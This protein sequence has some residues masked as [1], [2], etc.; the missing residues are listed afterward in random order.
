MNRKYILIAASL[1]AIAGC[2]KEP[3]VVDNGN[4]DLNNSS[5]KI[6]TTKTAL[7]PEDLDYVNSQIKL[8][9]VIKNGDSYS[10]LINGDI[11]SYA[12][13]VWTYANEPTSKYQWLVDNGGSKTKVDHFFFG[14][15]NQDKDNNKA[16]DLFGSGL[17][18]NGSGSSYSVAIPSTTMTLTSAQFD[19]S[20]IDMVQRSR[21]ESNYSPVELTL[22]HYFT[23]FAIK[24]HNYT[25]DQITITGIKLYGI[26]NVNSGSIAFDTEECTSTPSYGTGS[27]TWATAAAGLQLVGSSNIAIS[28]DSEVSN[29]IT[30]TGKLTTATDAYY[31]MWPQSASDLGSNAKLDITYQVNGGAAVTATVG[32][33]PTD[34]TYGWAAG[35]K[36]NV[37]IAFRDKAV[38]LTATVQPWDNIEPEINY[39]GTLSL[40]ENG[41]LAFVG[42]GTTC[43]VDE[44]TRTVYFKGGNPITFNFTL[45]S[46]L[47]ATWM[48]T[49]VG[50]FDAFEIDNETQNPL[51][52][53]PYSTHGDGDDYNYGTIDGNT[54]TVTIF[55]VIADPQRDFKIR[56]QFAVRTSSGLVYSADELV[57][58][59]NDSSTYYTIV[60]QAS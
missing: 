3:A 47:D 22:Q 42:N 7:D 60:L 39:S 5:I 55:P 52:G 41:G 28:A 23:C 16:S 40:K 25:T 27:S 53:Q 15:L 6:S 12:T 17:T 11:A 26:K 33:R 58:G 20:Y 35:T 50:D 36:H 13:P 49:K 14:W 2:E 32:I 1:L 24:A 30:S 37:E 51:T 54:A 48:I 29:V 31:L 18:L 34:A 57:Q 21:D 56:L 4:G 10:Y 9:D 19:M 38:T 59:S 46:P 44:A 8:Y 45:E 43:T